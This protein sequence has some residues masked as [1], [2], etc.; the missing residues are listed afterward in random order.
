VLRSVR[1]AAPTV[2]VATAPAEL[3]DITARE[4]EVM[5]LA[6]GY[7]NREIGRTLFVAE[8]TVKNHV[9][10]LL[11][12]LGVRDRTQVVIKALERGYVR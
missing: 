2:T 7:S 5:Q 4:R 3:D 11:A 10:N 8:G 1:P 12:K 6:A 9:L